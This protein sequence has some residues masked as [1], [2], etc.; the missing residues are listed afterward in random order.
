MYNTTEKFNDNGLEL[1][2]VLKSCIKNYCR[3]SIRENDLQFIGNNIITTVSD[4]IL[5]NGEK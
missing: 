2:E 3:L 5:L 1:F 4:E